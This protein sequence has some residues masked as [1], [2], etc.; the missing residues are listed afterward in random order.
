MAG[1]WFEKPERASGES[2]AERSF[3]LTT[4]GASWSWPCTLR[5]DEFGG[6]RPTT[7]KNAIGY[8]SFC[9]GRSRSK[10]QSWMSFAI[11]LGISEVSIEISLSRVT[12]QL[13]QQKRKSFVNRRFAR[14]PASQK[15]C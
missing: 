1:F 8:F 13:G 3:G 6:P 4:D 2:T 10:C 11:D 9:Q 14:Y 12:Y 5:A 15:N 7:L